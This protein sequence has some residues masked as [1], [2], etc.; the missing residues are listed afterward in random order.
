MTKIASQE[1]STP[2]PVGATDAGPSSGDTSRER[3]SLDLYL[4]RTRRRSAVLFVTRRAL[5]S[6]APSQKDRF[7]RFIRRLMRSRNGVVRWVGRVSRMGHRY[8]QRLEDRIDPPQQMIARNAVVEAKLIKQTVLPTQL[9]THHGPDPFAA[10]VK[11][12]NHGTIL[13]S[14]GV[15]QQPQP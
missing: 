5:A 11:T 12:L 8:Y 14:T 6:Y 7:L 9:T 2:R 10:S 15:L 3:P 1:T 13:S 4:V